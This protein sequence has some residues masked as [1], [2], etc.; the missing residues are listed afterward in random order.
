MTDKMIYQIALTMI[1]GVGDV[2]ARHLLE[3]FGEA[4]AVFAEKQR[5]LEKVPGIGS[6][7]VAKIRDPEVLKRAEKEA[8]FVSKNKIGVYFLADEG[9]PTRLRECPDAPVLLYYKGKADLNVA[10]IISIVGTRNITD[11]GKELT[12]RLVKELSE[13]FPD[14]LIVSGLAYGTDVLAHRSALKNNLPTAAVLA[15][16]LDRIYPSAHR[17]TA[18]E[19]LEQGGLLTDFPSG[20]NPDRSN[21]VMRNRIVA[22][23]SDATVVV[24]S[25]EKGGSLITANMAFS[26]GRDVFSFPGRVTDTH[27]CGCN[28]LIRGNK[29]ALITSA[30][31]LVSALCWDVGGSPKKAAAETC[32][33]FLDNAEDID[34]I[35]S[36]LR[37]H[38]EIHV[39]QL[40]I[41]A[42]MPVHQ[43]SPLLFELELSGV[44]KA[45]P[46]GVYRLV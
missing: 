18:V 29:A 35:V 45:L 11:Y 33:P 27:S 28:A 7:L 24:E 17:N 37:K 3:A 42:D 6:A 20:T 38:G 12:E 40:A 4:E 10:R 1:D 8:E 14:V 34:P 16:G 31:D 23:L 9:Y 43:L 5:L 39:N 13:A 32:L 15:H 44:I 41:A 25:A 21:F 26:Y 19:M 36:L 46:G 22:G 2:L 30:A